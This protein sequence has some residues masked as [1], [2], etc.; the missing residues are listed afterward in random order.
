MSDE[1]AAWLEYQVRMG[2]RLDLENLKKLERDLYKAI[3]Q[4][5]FLMGRTR[6]VRT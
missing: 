6:T 4:D 5:G 1:D 3:F 2:D